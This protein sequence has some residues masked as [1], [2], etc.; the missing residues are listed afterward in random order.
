MKLPSCQQA[1]SSSKQ[2]RHSLTKSVSDETSY[3]TGQ[4]GTKEIPLIP[5]TRHLAARPPPRVLSSIN[6]QSQSHELPRRGDIDKSATS[7]T[8]TQ[9]RQQQCNVIFVQADGLSLRGRPTPSTGSRSRKGAGRHTILTDNNTQDGTE[10]IH[11]WCAMWCSFS[12]LDTDGNP[13]ACCDH[14]MS[15]S[16]VCAVSHPVIR[17]VPR[18]LRSPDHTTTNTWLCEQCVKQQHQKK[19]GLEHHFRAMD[20][21]P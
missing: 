19:L 17:V 11:G 14:K 16:S 8:R 9:Q 21:S 5:S 6:H 1:Q 4:R 2:C 12:W 15:M 3:C 20:F 7:A 18:L 13:R 10:S